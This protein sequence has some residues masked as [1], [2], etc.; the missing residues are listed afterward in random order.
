MNS[1]RVK[2]DALPAGSTLKPENGAA[3]A[4]RRRQAR[5]A[6]TLV[7]VLLAGVA[8]AFD[9][10]FAA[11]RGAAV[12]PAASSNL[13]LSAPIDRW[14]EA[15]PLGNG[16]V[17]GLLWGQGQQLKLSLDRGDLWDLRTP[18]T[19][20]RKDWTY[21]TMQRLAAAKDQAKMVEL[22]DTPYGAVAYPTKIPAGRLELT[23]APSQSAKA[24]HLDL[25][26]AIGRADVGKPGP[27]E[28]FFAAA[29]P[30]APLAML[31]VPG[32]AP[33]WRLIAPDSVKQLG[34]PPAKH[35][36]EGD[37]RWTLQEATLGLKVAVVV[38]SRRVG[39]ATEMAVIVAS[40]Q[41][42]PDPV[43]FGKKRVAAALEAG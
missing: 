40:T 2:K 5:R 10:N 38:G 16:L 12:G 7:V 26:A 43:T 41:D 9:R 13:E 25:A 31:R 14:D 23:L 20:L 6:W 24:F 1:E 11:E 22:F 33:T 39:E 17:G 32:P 21:A 30:A 19:L 28:V 35:G 8:G 3:D 27:V 4:R 18:E 15:I 42:S 37:L 34:Y 36:S 29:G